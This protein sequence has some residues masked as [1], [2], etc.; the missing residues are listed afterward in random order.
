MNLHPIPLGN[1]G[2]VIDFH[3][4]LSNVRRTG[5]RGGNTVARW[6]RSNMAANT[7]A[8]VNRESPA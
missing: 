5:L 6:P 1:S 4:V 7:M 3:G 2:P 8:P